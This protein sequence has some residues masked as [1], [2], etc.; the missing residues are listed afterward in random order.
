MAV[1]SG[2]PPAASLEGH[3][4]P[5]GCRPSRQ[6]TKDSIPPSPAERAP[7]GNPRPGQEQAGPGGQPCGGARTRPRGKGPVW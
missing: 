1:G 2:Q 5:W 4:Q 7:P 6:L 3:G